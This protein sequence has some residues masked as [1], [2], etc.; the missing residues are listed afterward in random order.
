MIPYGSASASGRKVGFAS[1]SNKNPDPY[2]IK[3]RIRIRIRFRIRVI[4][5]I[6]ILIRISIEV[7]RIYNTGDDKK[8]RQFLVLLMNLFIVNKTAVNTMSTG[9]V[10]F[11]FQL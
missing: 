5:R 7:M 4:S 3:I 8:Y 10:F 1:A 2:Q 11:L 6:R 9:T